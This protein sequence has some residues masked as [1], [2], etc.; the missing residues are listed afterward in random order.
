MKSVIIIPYFGK[1]LPKFFPLYLKSLEFNKEIDILF[2]SDL[3][4]N[5]TYPANFIYKKFT[6][7]EY[8]KLFKTKI[9][10]DCEIK[11]PYKL[12][13]HKPLYGQVFSDEIRHY[14]YWGF[15]D[16]DLI[17]GDLHSFF[18]Q[19]TKAHNYDIVSFRKNWVSGSTCF[20]KNQEKIN[21]LYLL[22]ADWK[23]VKDEKY[24]GFDEIS[25]LSNDQS[26]FSELLKGT[27][28]SSIKTEIESFTQVI[29]KNKTSLNIKFE[30]VIK[31]SISKGMILKWDC[32]KVSIK[33]SQDISFKENTEFASYHF[34]T[35]K[36]NP[37]FSFPNWKVIPDTFFITQY[38]FH[39]TLSEIPLARFY[40]IFKVSSHF[41]KKLVYI[42]TYKNAWKRILY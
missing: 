8:K 16:I 15:G 40:S 39:K 34:I 5:I 35:E 30:T 7:K 27:P 10:I 21:K 42:K 13:D 3:D 26:V 24:Y 9:G 28:I 22:S 12:C 17:F 2:F 23:K 25:C 33:K 38:G 18:I 37:L 19:P 41:L 11:N 6:Q 14:D 31:E 4:I 29:F 36:T 20:F 1:K 32:G